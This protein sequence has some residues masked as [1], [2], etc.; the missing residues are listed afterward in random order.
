MEDDRREF[1]RQGIFWL[2]YCSETENLLGFIIELSISGIRLWVKDMPN[3]H[4]DEFSV[5]IKTPRELKI[6]KLQ[7]KLKKVWSKPLHDNS[8]ILDMGCHF[9][10]A[11]NQEISNLK[12][13]I[14]FFDKQE[15]Y[16]F[17]E[18]ENVVHQLQD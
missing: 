8:N 13:L 1:E 4:D 16:F 2:V 17:K 18:I 14:S 10:D 5:L 15:D 12:Q 7:F 9:I 11:N 6:E 3:I